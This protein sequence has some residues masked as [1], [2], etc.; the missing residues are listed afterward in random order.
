MGASAGAVASTSGFRFFFAR[1]L[2]AN[3]HCGQAKIAFYPTHNTVDL[4]LDLDLD[5][6]LN[7]FTLTSSRY[8][9]MQVTTILC[10]TIFYGLFPTSC[11]CPQQDRLR[12]LSIEGSNGES[13]SHFIA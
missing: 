10:T 11:V 1:A 4:D 3:G 12:A 5:F 7:S 8:R 6:G 13:Y 2:S 9:D